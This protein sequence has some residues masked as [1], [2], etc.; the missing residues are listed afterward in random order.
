MESGQTIV[1]VKVRL[2]PDQALEEEGK[3]ILP[4][5]TLSVLEFR[6]RRKTRMPMPRRLLRRIVMPVVMRI[7]VGAGEGSVEGE[8]WASGARK[9]AELTARVRLLE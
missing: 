2:H 6:T 7:A 1:T 9:Q 8:D 5:S 4:Q 3:I